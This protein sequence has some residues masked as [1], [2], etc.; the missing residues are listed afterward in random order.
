M[1]E[2]VAV[3]VVAAVVVGDSMVV[4]V[5]VAELEELVVPVGPLRCSEARPFAF[6]IG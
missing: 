1:E 3:A 2:L 4:A 5:V 6:D